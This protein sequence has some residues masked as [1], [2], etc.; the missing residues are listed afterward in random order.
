VELRNQD[1]VA[2]TQ[3]HVKNLPTG[4]IY[5]EKELH[6]IHEITNLLARIVI[7]KIKNEEQLVNLLRTIPV[8]NHDKNW[9]CRTW[10]CSTLDALK[11]DN[12]ALGTSI[13]DWEKI[14]EVA[15]SYVGQK[16]ESGRYRTEQDILGPKPIWDML[17]GKEKRA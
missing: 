16:T 14:E 9:R 17:E 5:E 7:A 3:Y 13:V 15:R 11:D 4:W 8:V 12:L 10:I 6:N 1:T 2:G